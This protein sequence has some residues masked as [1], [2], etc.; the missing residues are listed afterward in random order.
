MMYCLDCYCNVYI[1]E[2]FFEGLKPYFVHKFLRCIDEI[3]GSDAVC[4]SWL[5]LLLTIATDV[6]ADA[7]NLQNNLLFAAGH[8]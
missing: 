3:L 6:D 1:P 4:D 5:G 2:D 8:I 7:C